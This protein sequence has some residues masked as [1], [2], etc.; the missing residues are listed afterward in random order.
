MIYLLLEIVILNKFIASLGTEL[1]Y[2][3]KNYPTQILS[4]AHMIIYGHLSLEQT[5]RSIDDKTT[6]VF[7]EKFRTIAPLANS[8]GINHC[9]NILDKLIKSFSHPG[10]GFESYM[11]HYLNKK[12]YIKCYEE[13]IRIMAEKF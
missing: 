1:D 2:L 4:H 6:D 11:N 9:K 8:E 7:F 3:I 5:Y 13:V 12:F 10:S